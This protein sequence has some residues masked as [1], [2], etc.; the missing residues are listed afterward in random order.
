MLKQFLIV[1]AVTIAAGH[2]LEALAGETYWT[3]WLNRDRPGGVGDYETFSD[4]L[5]AG[6]VCKT[7]CG[8]QCQTTNG[9]N[10]DQSGQ[11]YTCAQDKGGICVNKKQANGARCLDYRV[12][13][14]CYR[15][16]WTPWLDRDNAGGKGDYETLGAFLEEG[17][18]CPKPEKI[19]CQ[20]TDGQDS[21]TTGQV[22][23]CNTAVGGFCINADQSGGSR[24][25]D[26]RVRFLCPR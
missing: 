19:E 18:A 10:W 15:P 2:A 22:Y 26:Y 7:P 11:V 24:C 20:T 8:I 16:K 14:Q 25:R 3:P 17:K 5:K 12:R 1:L 9:K 13:F 6:K 21:S 23:T 4:F